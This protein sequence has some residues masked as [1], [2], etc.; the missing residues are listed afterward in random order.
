MN[1]FKRAKLVFNIFP[2]VLFIANILTVYITITLLSETSLNFAYDF[3]K[4]IIKLSI[5]LRWMITYIIPFATAMI[6]MLFI[7]K[8]IAKAIRENTVP[9]KLKLTVIRLPLILNSLS[10]LG[11]MV[12]SLLVVITAIITKEICLQSIKDFFGFTALYFLTNFIIGFL[13]FIIG[14]YITDLLNRKLVI[15]HFFPNGE[16]SKYAGMFRVTIIKKMFLFY[17]A[18]GLF[19]QYILFLAIDNFSRENP[20]LM[21]KYLLIAYFIVI[22]SVFSI[23]LTFIIAKSLHLPL[24]EMRTATDQIAKQNYDVNIRVLTGD[25]FGVLGD[26][27]NSMARELKEKEFIKD[28]FGKIVDPGV[29]D[30]LLKGNISLGGDIKTATVMFSDIIGFTEISEKLKPEEV[31]DLLNQYFTVVSIIIKKNRGF[32][33]KFI[34]DSVMA[35][36]NLPLPTPDHAFQSVLSALEIIEAEKQLSTAFELKGISLNSGYGIHTGEL[37]AGNIGSNDRMEYTVIGDNVNIASRLQ[38]LTRY[39]ETPLIISS[40]TKSLMGDDSRLLT[41]FIDCIRVKGRSKPITI[42]QVLDPFGEK[43][44]DNVS[45]SASYFD[46]MRALYTEGRFEDAM[47]ILEKLID[48]YPDDGVLSVYYKRCS[49]FAKYPPVDVWDGIYNFAG[50]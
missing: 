6:P 27:I 13:C 33:N 50:K 49:K 3:D 11:W 43:H 20:E 2:A 22:F 14:Y 38:S 18:V 39:Y 1:N 30:H 37:L 29:R 35:V 36:F 31:V 7:M 4:V 23:W 42:Y 17:F 28:T 47:R 41:R 16:L 21:H 24:S 25:E 10:I 12:N 9:E 34:G 45:K 32:V 46:D 44:I 40:E 19:P 8:P 5:Y 15:P 48:N 26:T